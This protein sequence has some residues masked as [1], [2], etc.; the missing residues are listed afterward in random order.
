MNNF[1]YA[2]G[3]ISCMI[4][5]CPYFRTGN[6]EV[7][8]R[9]HPQVMSILTNLTT[10]IFPIE[11]HGMLHFIHLFHQMQKTHDSTHYQHALDVGVSYTQ[12]EVQR[13]HF[14]HSGQYQGEH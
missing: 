5:T 10:L 6:W 1:E 9:Q 3:F 14:G 13:I 4:P 12:R 7:L 2:T 11:C 8:L